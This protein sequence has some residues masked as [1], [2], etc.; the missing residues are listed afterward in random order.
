MPPGSSSACAPACRRR[1]P[2]QRGLLGGEVGP[3]RHLDLLGQVAGDG[4]VGLD[5]AQHERPGDQ[6]QPARRFG[7]A[8]SFSMGT[9][10][11]SRKLAALPSRPG[12]VASRTARR[13][14]SRFSTGVPVRATRCARRAA[15]G[16][17]GP[18]RVAAFLTCCAS[19]SAT[20]RHGTRGEVVDVAHQ[21][22]VGGDDEVVLA[23][24]PGEVGPARTPGAVLDVDPQPRREPGGLGHP[25]PDD[26]HGADEQR[27]RRGRRR[28]RAAAAP[29]AAPSCPAP[30]R[31]RGRP[32][33]PGCDIAA[34]QVSPRRW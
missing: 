20:R 3:H 10:K 29:A 14:S 7:P 33:A 22:P 12:F 27:R 18:A 16:P 4:G 26:R 6:R 17:R 5:P 31:R 11:A 19:S 30:C 21:Q 34:S 1:P 24:P 25:V 8:P 32:R 9:A 13:S 28:A 15:R 2:V 23:R